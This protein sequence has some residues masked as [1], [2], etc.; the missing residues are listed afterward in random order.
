MPDE[1]AY[2]NPSLRTMIHL[3]LWDR[4]ANDERSSDNGQPHGCQQQVTNG[5]N[6]IRDMHGCIDDST[7]AS[8][9]P[10]ENPG[11]MYP[12][13]HVY[14]TEEVNDL[15]GKGAQIP[16]T[17]YRVQRITGK[18]EPVKNS[19]TPPSGDY[20]DQG[21]Q[22]SECTRWA[23]PILTV[24]DKSSCVN[25]PTT[26]ESCTA[27]AVTPVSKCECSVKALIT[28]SCKTYNYTPITSHRPGL[29]TSLDDAVPGYPVVTVHAA[30]D[31]NLARIKSY[32]FTNTDPK[33]DLSN[34]IIIDP[35]NFFDLSLYR[36]GA[37][38][39][40]GYNKVSAGGLVETFDTCPVM[41][42]TG[43]YGGICDPT[44]NAGCNLP[45]Y[46]VG[47]QTAFSDAKGN[48]FN[49]NDYPIKW[50]GYV[51]SWAVLTADQ[52]LEN[53]KDRRTAGG[54]SLY[55]KGKYIN[56]NPVL[57]I[58][59]A[60]DYCDIQER[61]SVPVT[62][63]GTGSKPDMPCIQYLQYQA[64]DPAGKVYTFV[65]LY[66]PDEDP[67][68]ENHIEFDTARL[69]D[70]G[71]NGKPDKSK[72]VPGTGSDVDIGG[73]GS[74]NGFLSFKDSRNPIAIYNDRSKSLVGLPAIIK[75]NYDGSKK[76]VF[77]A[78]GKRVSGPV[79]ST[80]NAPTAGEYLGIDAATG[81]VDTSKGTGILMEPGTMSF[82]KMPYDLIIS[83]DSAPCAVISYPVT[84]EQ[85]VFIPTNTEAEFQS[86]VAAAADGKTGGVKIRRCSASYQ[87]NALAAKSGEV[88]AAGNAVQGTETWTGMLSCGDLTKR[89]ACNQ[90]KM[91]TAMRYCQLEN[92][93][94]NS[95]G[96]C[97]GATDPDDKRVNFTNEAVDGEVLVNP[98][99]AASKCYFSAAC[100][101]KKAAECPSENSSGGH[102][103]CLSADTKITMADGTQK[104]IAKIKAG[105]MV[106]AFD[107]KNT[108]NSILKKAKVIATAV[109]KKQEI[110]KINDLRIT[111]KHKIVLAS[112]RA[113]MASDIRIGDKIMG[114]DG[115]FMTVEKID[116]HQAPIT[117]YNLVLDSSSD[118]YIA[119]NV[120]VLSYPKL[121]GMEN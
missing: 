45:V 44:G 103:F 90:T 58:Q 32:I 101:N 95:C 65:N 85:K 76:P 36:P 80:E 68:D 52:Y 14:S 4:R 15:G 110:I 19:P 87:K 23:N 6:N 99:F 64:N 39:D 109:T 55:L 2:A 84:D 92:G 51:K 38:Y 111:P 49:Y 5:C 75:A 116:S 113:V 98:R 24:K 33:A 34:F 21:T 16:S 77:D 17:Y 81:N 35:S 61:T 11:Y 43:G 83:G 118:G 108:R 29:A 37:P 42:L 54:A 50:S 93:T 114:A 1:D 71:E 102:V 31:P 82:V 63:S 104:A 28:E 88:A 40:S 12:V 57:M 115:L 20:I 60:D 112:G 86:F 66:S 89:P 25:S 62:Q 120:R 121:K 72:P 27:R 9:V 70:I 26:E 67:H 96:S 47:P 97:S 48:S 94:L 46:W 79:L 107:G 22:Q 7:G 117:V 18:G 13:T 53:I 78:K 119:N 106:M 3:P 91:I 100:F 105:E 73:D 59:R 41:G 8:M 74:R 10:G 56:E 30:P 69:Y